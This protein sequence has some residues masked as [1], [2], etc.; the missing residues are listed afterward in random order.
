MDEMNMDAMDD[1]PLEAMADATGD[2]AGDGAP[3]E[4]PS[5]YAGCTTYEDRTATNASREVDFGGALGMN[6]VPKCSM[7]KAGQS[8]IFVGNFAIHPLA[9]VCG[10]ADVIVDGT[11]T[12][13]QFMFTTPGTY[14]YKCVVHEAFG[15]KGSIQVVP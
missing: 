2:S 6:F 5:S 13:A 14:N 4:C 8:V 15:M 1:A 7:I 3:A 10:P 11:G 9:Q 12:S